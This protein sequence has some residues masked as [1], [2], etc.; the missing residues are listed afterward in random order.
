MFVSIS[1]ILSDSIADD[2][3]DG[4]TVP[5][6]S[7]CSFLSDSIADDVVDGDFPTSTRPLLRPGQIPSRTMSLMG[8]RTDRQ[9]APGDESDSI[10]DDVV[11]GDVKC[12]SLIR[13]S[14]F[15]VRFHR[16]RCR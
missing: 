1:A 4:D 8:T 6:E 12:P 13:S 15:R 16:G 9:P 7:Q 3:V 2:V 5:E 11:D 10:A 14:C